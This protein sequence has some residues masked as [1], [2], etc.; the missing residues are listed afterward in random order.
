MIVHSIATIQQIQAYK[1]N[2][3]YTHRILD[4]TIY[5][6]NTTSTRPYDFNTTKAHLND[7]QHHD[8][9]S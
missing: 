9:T 7:F 5:N 2:T 3:F 6:N 1:N 4:P 8:S